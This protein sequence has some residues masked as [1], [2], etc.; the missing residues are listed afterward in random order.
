VTSPSS[1]DGLAPPFRGPRSALTLP[2]S[3]ASSWRKAASFLS[4]FAR[5]CCSSRTTPSATPSGEFSGDATVRGLRLG[6]SLRRNQRGDHRLDRFIGEFE[7][8]DM[9]PVTS[10]LAGSA[11]AFPAGNERARP[12]N[13]LKRGH[14]RQQCLA[15]RAGVCRWR[16]AE[17]WRCRLGLIRADAAEEVARASQMQPGGGGGAG[18]SSNTYTPLL[19]QVMPTA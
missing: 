7:R 3:S 15:C 9:Q 14:R 6:Q 4:L 11:A 8:P 13:G 2:R 12:V 1:P 5:S 19:R 10:S 16:R 18:V 17:C